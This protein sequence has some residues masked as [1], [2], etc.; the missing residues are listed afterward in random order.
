MRH[1]IEILLRFNMKRIYVYNAGENAWIEI[2]SE[3]ILLQI[4]QFNFN[5]FQEISQTCT[6]SQKYIMEN[7]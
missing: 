1:F 7:S 5:N 3:Q 2:F 6:N 4:K